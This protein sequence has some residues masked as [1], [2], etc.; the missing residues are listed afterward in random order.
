M[1]S[2]A[3]ICLFAPLAGV[4]ALTLA[5]SRISRTAAAWAGTL[6]AFVSFG[7]AVAELVAMLGEDASRRAHTFTAY[8]W[9][10]SGRSCQNPISR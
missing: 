1:I 7:A 9:A 5:G 4:A 2:G 10:G 3:W 8:T 6:F